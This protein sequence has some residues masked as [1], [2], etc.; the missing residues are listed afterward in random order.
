M[1]T[2][3][4][5]A[6]AKILATIAICFAGYG[7]YSDS[8]VYPI[9]TSILEE[10]PD[11]SVGCTNMF[12]T[13]ASAIAAIFAAFL[14]GVLVKY[15]RKRT[16]IILGT[17]AFFVG[18]VAGFF[19]RNMGFLIAMRALDGFSDGMLATA[20]AVMITQIFQ[21]EKE[22]SRVFALYIV[23]SL[24]LS[25]I[26]GSLSGVLCTIGWRYSFLANSASFIP[27]LLAVFFLPDTPLEPLVKRTREKL[28][29]KPAKPLGAIG[30]YLLL[31]ALAFVCSICSSFYVSE[32]AIGNSVLVG[33][34]QSVGKIVCLVITLCFT[35]IYVRFKKFIPFFSCMSFTAI[36]LLLYFWPSAVMLFLAMAI[37]NVGMSLIPTYFELKVSQ[38]TPEARMGLMMGLYTISIY[39]ANLLCPYVPTTLQAVMGSSTYT[40]TYVPVAV[41]MGA[42]S[43][44]YLVRLV[45]G[46]EQRSLDSYG[47]EL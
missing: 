6:R 3:Q 40:A 39:G 15:I 36:Y 29:W 1:Q 43:L 45:S 41:I 19:A 30:M 34:S 12:L 27:I 17:T 16:L 9:I 11:T 32:N 35:P 24:V 20:S 10:F 25:I 37:L 31:S 13:G 2:G 23:A 26:S 8:V 22:R 14:T 42:I 47:R 4:Y 46:R 18:G 44:F 28:R 5:S 21:E 38:N 33:F 7:A